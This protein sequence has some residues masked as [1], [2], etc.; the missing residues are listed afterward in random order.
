MRHCGIAALRQRREEDKLILVLRHCGIAALRHSGRE[1]RRDVNFAAFRQR[2][3]E[4]KIIRA[5]RQ[6]RIAAMR[7]RKGK[8]N[9]SCIP[10]LRHY[11]I[12]AEKKGVK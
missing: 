6:C 5:L 7:Q 10:S 1:K 12:P 3:E 4:D 8:V 2:R 9:H 11:G